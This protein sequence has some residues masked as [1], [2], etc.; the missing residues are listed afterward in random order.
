MFDQILLT[1]F[2]VFGGHDV[3]P[4]QLVA[5]HFIQH[6]RKG[7]SCSVVEVTAKDADA[8]IEKAKQQVLC[9]K[10]KKILNLHFGVGPNKVYY[11]EQICYNNKDFRIPDN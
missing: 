5:E 3:N 6:P 2:K 11:L 8:Y 7:V 4:T 1:G 10:D 9:S